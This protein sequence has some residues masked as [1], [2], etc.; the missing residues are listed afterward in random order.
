MEIKE[1]KCP[2][3]SGAVKFDSEIQK[4]KCPYCDTEFDMEALADYQKAI[5]APETD[6]VE[7][8][9]SR[10]GSEWEE[11]DL[12][13]LST[14]SCPSCGAE[15]IGD[16]N[17]IATVC[18][19]CGNTQIVRQ[20]IQG[21]L[22]PEY[23]IPFH[24]DKKAAVD[25]LKQFY[26]KKRLLPNFFKDENRVNGIQALYVP[27]WLF[28]AKAQGSAGYK[29]T[30][31][32][33]WVDTNYSYTKIDHYSV[34]R[35]GS[36]GFE[37][38]SVDGS[39]KMDDAYM[40][41]IEPFDYSKIKDF[42]SAYLSGYL[43]EKYDVG[44]DASKERAVKRIKNSVE[45]QFAKSVQGYATVTKERSSVNVQDGK[46]SYALFPVWVLNTKYKNET[47]QFI[48]NGQSGRLV[49]RLPVDKG[50]VARYM[51]MFTAG[52]GAVFTLIIQL[53]RIFI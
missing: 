15:L 8:D 34:I 53:L 11:Q 27:F 9:T 21:L 18:P 43:A 39:E 47:Y 44:I 5:T 52:I 25:T 3:C 42:Q 19:C 23:V 30:K 24:L 36:L 46:V 31:I 6:N 37:K 20:R 50:K 45:S 17:T 12:G 1:Y 22:K 13:D 29:A 16:N 33:K 14:G 49:G 28:D 4:M 2:N 38:I 35:E 10:A 7:L 48:M 26:N 41:A 51:L 40:D 32:K